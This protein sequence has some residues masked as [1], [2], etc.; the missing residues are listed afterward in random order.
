MKGV[1]DAMVLEYRVGL[2][3]FF[4]ERIARH[5]MVF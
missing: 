5:S 2:R 1:V 3:V 4:R